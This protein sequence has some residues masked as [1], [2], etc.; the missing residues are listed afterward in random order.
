MDKTTQIDYKMTGK[1][2]FS[3]LKDIIKNFATNNT[4]EN[5]I[6]NSLISLENVKEE[7]KR[8]G[9]TKRMEKLL[10]DFLG[11]TKNKKTKKVKQQNEIA[12]E[13]NKTVEN[14]EI[15]IEIN[16]KEDREL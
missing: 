14:K 16:E 5:E 12:T 8:L 11:T 6:T 4:N 2:F 9:S 10:E 1:D 3:T 13:I 15:K 7:E